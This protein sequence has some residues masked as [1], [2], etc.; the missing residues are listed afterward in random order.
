MFVAWNACDF[1][2]DTFPKTVQ[3]FKYADNEPPGFR[4]L[5]SDL[6]WQ[7]QS[8]LSFHSHLFVDHCLHCHLHLTSTPNNHL[9]RGLGGLG[10]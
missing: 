8:E 4:L 5:G 1:Y 10:K 9:R 2:L 7:S 3:C 6:G